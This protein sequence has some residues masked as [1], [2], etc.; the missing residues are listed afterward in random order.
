MRNCTGL[1]FASIGRRRNKKTAGELSIVE[2]GTGVRERSEHRESADLARV[3][4][5]ST[6]ERNSS[7]LT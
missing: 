7:K 2:E 1:A 3:A 6:R 4:H 5:G